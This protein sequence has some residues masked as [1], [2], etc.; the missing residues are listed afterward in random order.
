[1]LRRLEVRNLAVIEEASLELGPGLNALTGETGAGKS[2]LVDALALLLGARP[3]GLV[4][5]YGDSLLVTAFFETE[6][7]ERVLS[8]RVGARSTPR[9][10]GEVVSLKELKEAA[11]ALLAI[12]AQHLP[13]ALLEEKKAQGLLDALVPEGLKKAY[14]EAYER[15]EALK[16]EREELLRAL[17]HRL[18]REDLL[19]FQLKEIEEARPRPGEEEALREEA[20][21]LR[22]LETLRQRGGR[23]LELLEKAQ[24]A[25][26][27]AGRELSAMARLDPGLG[28][29]GREAE[30]AEGALRAIRREVEAYLEGL[31][32]EPGRLEALE[33]RLALLERLKRK[34]GGRLEE[35]LAY[36]ERAREELSS[37]ERGEE[38]LEEVEKAL[39][40]A[41]RALRVHGEALSQARKEAAERLMA[42][43]EAEL[44]ALGL[45]QARFQVALEVLP[46]PGPEGL[47]RV[48]FLFSAHPLLPPGPLSGASGGELARIA[49]ALALLTGAEAPTVVLDEVDAGLGGETAWRVAERLARLAQGRQVLVVTHLPQIAARA[50]RHLRVAQEE[51][52]VRVEALEGEERVRELARLLSGEYTPEALAHARALLE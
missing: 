40:D 14:R 17:R 23:A 37:L 50:H 9:I 45:P 36:A 38:R 35:V 30:E 48:R 32:E 34:Y 39:V 2:L 51:G 29:L 28:P 43:M 12:H 21:R 24:E 13:L 15:R 4:G 31:E 42:G 16:R 47:E 27:L 20:L 44:P 49:L 46:E 26:G 52:R 5:P 7:G 1:M 25:L 18:E 33:E 41:E 22:H 11:E 10:D 3:E 19:R 8:R 6:T